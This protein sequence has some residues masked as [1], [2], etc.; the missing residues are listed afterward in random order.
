GPAVVTE[1]RPRADDIGGGCG[2]ADR[3]RGKAHEEGVVLGND[4]RHLRLLEHHL[5]D[6]DRPRVTGVAPRQV[7]AR[8][9]RPAQERLL[10]QKTRVW[11]GRAKRSGLSSTSLSTRRTRSA[12]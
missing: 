12:R 2:R 10:H 8:A 3:R 1:A 11:Y 4:P 7:A 9:R 6:E 5:A